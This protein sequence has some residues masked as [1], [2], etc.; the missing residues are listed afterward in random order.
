METPVSSSPVDGGP[1]AHAPKSTPQPEAPSS[2]W[3]S[4]LRELLRWC[5]PALILGLALR[6]ALTWSMPYG[7]VQ[8]DTSDYLTTIDHIIEK[9]EF[10]IHNKR[11]YLTP[12]LFAAAWLL[13]VPATIT[14]AAAQHVM[15]LIATLI[16]GALVR[17]WFRFWRIAIIPVTV[18]FT[19]NPSVLWYEHTLMGEA[20]FLFFTL[21]LVFAGTL[22]ALRPTTKRFIWFIVSMLL[23]FGTR[24][25]SKTYILFVL[26]LVVLVLWRQWKRLAIGVA[27]VVAS[28]LVAFHVSGD[29]DVSS[30]VYASVIRFAPTTSAST[31]G[32][33][34]E[35]NRIRDQARKYSSD[36][37]SQ[38]VRVSKYINHAVDT[39]AAAHVQGKKKVTAEESRIV[40]G[41][42]LETLKAE[43]VKTLMEPWLKFRLAIDAWS[44][45]C[46]DK[47]SLWERQRD[48]FIGKEWMT[49]V[50]SR[51][52]T[53]KAQTLEQIPDWVKAHYSAG[54]V[55]WFTRYQRNWNKQLIHF[56]TPDQPMKDRRW[57]HDFYGGVGH[58]LHTF[59]GLP[60]FYILGFLGMFAA[61]LRPPQLRAVHFA[62]VATVLG[63][64]YVCSMVGVTNG[65]FRFVYEPFFLLYFFF[66]FD[67]VADFWKDLRDRRVSSR[68]C[69]T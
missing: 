45:Y 56:R 41:L 59:P 30:L 31:P 27:A 29:R 16:V 66:L 42:L 67:C 68:A 44:S 43:P 26:A 51:G 60:Y 55:A 23:V 25:E 37:P 35:M 19:S 13:P 18:L 21:L 5:L 64:L 6:A 22:F 8:Y 32:I 53:G 11:S 61:V 57:V 49:T 7:Y 63:G 52:L 15:G 36:Y 24:L 34:P 2:A 69:S 1:D 47:Q 48:A 28:Y 3:K 4:S 12:T 46:W 40:R 58:W 39:Y 38:T 54:R 33:M 17:L 50:L 10:Y 65:R 20:Q 9:H 14:I 62:W